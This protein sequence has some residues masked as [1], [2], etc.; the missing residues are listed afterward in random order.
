MN[1]TK[2]TWDDHEKFY[3]HKFNNLEYYI[4]PLKDTNCKARAKGQII[5]PH[6]EA[7]ASNKERA[8]HSPAH[9]EQSCS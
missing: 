4:N 9:R 2:T 3:N 8:A 1:N 7:L 6:N 5:Y